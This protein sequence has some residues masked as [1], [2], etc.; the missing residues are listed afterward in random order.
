MTD[1]SNLTGAGKEELALALILWKDFKSQGKMDID[2]M[3]QTVKFTDMLG[4]TKEFQKMLSKVP[5]LEI[6]VRE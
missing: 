3:K 6:K 5:P 4:I 2:I 1:L